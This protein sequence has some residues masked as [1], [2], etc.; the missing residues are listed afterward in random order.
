MYPRSYFLFS[1]LFS[2]TLSSGAYEH[3]LS[4]SRKARTDPVP[5]GFDSGKRAGA[6]S[7]SRPQH[8]SHFFQARKQGSAVQTAQDKAATDKLLS[9]QLHSKRNTTCCC[10]CCSC[11]YYYHTTAVPPSTRCPR[12]RRTAYL[13]F[14]VF[15]FDVTTSRT[16]ARANKHVVW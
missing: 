14:L 8:Y 4:G 11:Y 3:C 15:A 7:L 1:A 12:R 5:Q 2:V 9:Q 16:G 10:C 13:P 6:T